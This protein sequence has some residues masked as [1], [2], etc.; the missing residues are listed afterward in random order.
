MQSNTRYFFI[1]SWVLNCLL[2][3]GALAQT[4]TDTLKAPSVSFFLSETLIQKTDYSVIDSGLQSFQQLLPYFKNYTQAYNYLGNMGSAYRDD[5]WGYDNSL[6]VIYRQNFYKAYQL[7][8]L[9]KG[10]D[11]L[12]NIHSQMD[13]YL[14]S[15]RE[16]WFN[17]NHYQR[18][19]K[20][21]G[22]GLQYSSI[23][24]PS[25]YKRAFTD[26][27][28]FSGYLLFETNNHR[29]SAFATYVSNK[30][31]NNLNGGLV[32]DTSLENTNGIDTKTLAVNLNDAQWLTRNRQGFFMQQYNLT[33]KHDTT[34]SKD[35]LIKSTISTKP[36]HYIQHRLNYQ[37]YGEL[38]TSNNDSVF[39]ADT[40]LDSIQTNDSS[41][42]KELNNDVFVHIENKGWLQLET[43]LQHQYMQI[44]QANSDTNINRLSYRIS[45]QSHMQKKANA[46]LYYE[47]NIVSNT[48]NFRLGASGRYYI[49]SDNSFL[50]AELLHAVQAPFFITQRYYSNH[51]L[52]QNNF[53]DV[54]R[55]ELKIKLSYKN[56]IAGILYSSAQNHI[57]FDSIGKPFQN[58]KAQSYTSFFTHLN[59]N[60]NKWYIIAKLQYNLSSDLVRLPAFNFHTNLY[61][62]SYAF[63]KALLFQTGIDA[64]YHSAYKGDGFMP[65]LHQFTLQDQTNIGNY[66]NIDAYAS[67]RIRTARFYIKFENFLAGFIGRNYYASAHY[68]LP[69]RTVR[70]GLQWSFYN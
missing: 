48:S 4:K 38:F 63:K 65:G 60:H 28:S 1:Y 31:D 6:N 8:V 35:T 30:V 25:L 54:K 27:K 52:W 39:W 56:Q 15:K 34:S 16:Q 19:S 68:P 51:F 29:Y 2:F 53:T 64:F 47:Q 23:V 45:V 58:N 26:L 40:F 33:Y 10:F 67:A 18:I 12:R 3:S 36:L 44:K 24:S 14:G 37:T 70:F 5:Y 11:K 41:S 20:N 17:F 43:G 13:F 7:E 21:F 69:G 22:A 9:P 66:F 57:W 61:Y 55:N 42:F 46:Q 32:A 59:Y 50:Q 62:Q 49:K